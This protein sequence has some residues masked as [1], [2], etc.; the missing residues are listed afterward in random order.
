[1]ADWNTA[2]NWMMDFEDA[3]RACAQVPDAAPSGVA[4]PCY[5]I[6]GIN[7]GAWPAEFAP[8]AALPPAER[9]PLVQQFY[10]NH[11][12]NPWYAQVISDDVCKRVFDFA[13]N[14]G[15][16]T[17]VRCLQQAVNSLLA[18]GVTPIPE[19]GGWGPATVGAVNAAD[20]AALQAAFQAK[21][22]AYYQAIAAANPS[23]AVYLNAW[24]ARAEK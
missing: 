12:W 6:S 1:M 7:S 18:L 23:K 2:Y 8:I 16:G 17:A 24:T 9:S 3:P 19:D 4:G 5:S 22:I 10:E 13:V 11:F 14:G 21:R 20:P 15:S